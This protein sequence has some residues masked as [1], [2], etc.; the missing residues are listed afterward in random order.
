[1]AKYVNSPSPKTSAPTGRVSLNGALP[2]LHSSKIAAIG[3][4]WLWFW[5]ELQK[6]RNANYSWLSLGAKV[7]LPRLAMH[8]L[9]P[10][11]ALKAAIGKA[12]EAVVELFRRSTKLPSPKYQ[13][14]QRTLFGVWRFLQVVLPCHLRYRKLDIVR[15]SDMLNYNTKTKPAALYIYIYIMG[16]PCCLLHFERREYNC[17]NDYS[18]VAQIY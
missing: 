12:W 9:D 5:Q 17:F 7:M 6:L 1:M 11:H 16:R 8:E 18:S 2:H 4:M 15:C 3:L 10:A 13:S 14:M